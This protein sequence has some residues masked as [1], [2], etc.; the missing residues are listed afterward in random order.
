VRAVHGW[1]LTLPRRSGIKAFH[2]RRKAAYCPGVRRRYMPPLP[3]SN[4]ILQPI[5]WPLM[6]P[7]LH[8]AAPT[9]LSWQDP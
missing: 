7:R 1:M 4:G 9:P 8:L 6:C 2:G 3:T 5:A